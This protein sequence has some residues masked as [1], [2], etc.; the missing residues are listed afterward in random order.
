MSSRKAVRIAGAGWA[1]RAEETTGGTVPSGMME[2][3]GSRNEEVNMKAGDMVKVVGAMRNGEIVSMRDGV[4]ATDT[5]NDATRNGGM[6]ARNGD[7]PGRGTFRSR[8]D[9]AR[10]CMTYSCAGA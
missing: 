10:A 8:G 9:S 6:V 7:T 3:V 1:R 5:M 2:A 4:Q